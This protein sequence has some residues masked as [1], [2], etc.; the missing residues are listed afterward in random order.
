[1]H[2]LAAINNN[3]EEWRALQHFDQDKPRLPLPYA[4]GGAF[5]KVGHTLSAI[6]LCSTADKKQ[7]S[8]FKS[9]YYKNE[10]GS[11]LKDVDITALSGSNAL[12][13]LLKQSFTPLSRNNILYFTYVFSPQNPSLKYMVNDMAIQLL[14]RA[15]KGIVLMTAEQE[16]AAKAQFD[17][18]LPVLRLRCGIDTAFYRVPS[19]LS[20]IPELQK[21]KVETLLTEPYVIMPGD[22]LR[23]NDDAIKF[24]ERTGI[25]LVR[26][27]QYS[28][29]SN[30]EKLKQ[31][32]AE[33]KLGD[34]LVVFENISYAFL[35]F[36][37][38]LTLFPLSNMIVQI[39]NSMT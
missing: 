33:R 21:S 17:D 35:R 16:T 27:S 1:M 5:L 25:R 15:A 8:P 14:S 11:A 20:D 2:L 3:V 26:I 22:E 12:K 13:A 32:I 10:L 37:Y 7:V 23:Y 4:F 18:S 36:L 9:L 34:R 28:S 6:D 31:D 38:Q 29:K 30:T 39:D 24:V 19:S